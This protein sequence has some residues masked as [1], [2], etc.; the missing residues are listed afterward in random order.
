MFLICQLNIPVPNYS[1]IFFANAQAPLS[2]TFV[3]DTFKLLRMSVGS[4][5]SQYRMLSSR[6]NMASEGLT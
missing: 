5:D 2:I 1:F 4:V 6:L 3:D